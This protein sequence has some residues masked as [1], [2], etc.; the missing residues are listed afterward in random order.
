MRELSI[1]YFKTSRIAVHAFH[2]TA[3][4]SLNSLTSISSLRYHRKILLIHLSIHS[5]PKLP[6]LPYTRQSFSAIRTT[7]SYTLHVTIQSHNILR[8]LR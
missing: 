4:A 6:R 8:L 3:C 5:N 7:S 2:T 1:D